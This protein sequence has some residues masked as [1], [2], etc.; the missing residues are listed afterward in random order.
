MQDSDYLVNVL[1]QGCYQKITE[2]A[3]CS[4]FFVANFVII[5]PLIR[6]VLTAG[7]FAAMF[8]NNLCLCF[9]S[10]GQDRN[11]KIFARAKVS[12]WNYTVLNNKQGLNTG[13]NRQIRHL[14]YFTFFL[15]CSSSPHL[16]TLRLWSNTCYILH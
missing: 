11:N 8:G 14:D 5:F 15:K 4:I 10:E 2:F 3:L 7:S 6:V 12:N 9:K 16:L 1:L 13:R